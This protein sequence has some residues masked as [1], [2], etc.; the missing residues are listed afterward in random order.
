[1]INCGYIRCITHHGYTYLPDFKQNKI[2]NLSSEIL[3]K[4]RGGSRISKS[5]ISK[6]LGQD[7][8][9]RCFIKDLRMQVLST[10]PPLSSFTSSSSLSS[11]SSP[12]HHPPTVKS[13]DLCY[14]FRVP[15]TIYP[16][17]NKDAYQTC[18]QPLIYKPLYPSKRT[19]VVLLCEH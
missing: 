6:Q 5:R 19:P 1:M 12:N 15:G 4:K 8:G 14:N 10:V 16:G 2:T 17:K 3:E 7:L 18:K 11:P 9:R 13:W